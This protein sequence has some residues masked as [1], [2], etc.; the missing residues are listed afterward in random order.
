MENMN[1]YMKPVVKD[2]G[3]YLAFYPAHEGG[4]SLNIKDVVAYIN[5]QGY[6][7]YDLIA[8]DRAIKSPEPQEVYIG[9]SNGNPFHEKVSI[10]LSEDNMLVYCTFYPAA[11]DTGNPATLEDIQDALTFQKV[12]YGI[13]DTAVN[14]LLQNREYCTRYLIGKG[15]PPKKGKDAEIQYFFSINRSLKPKHNEDGSVNYH[16]LDIISRVEKGQ[17]LARLIPSVPGEPGYNVLG[18]ELKPRDVQEL[19]LTY[20]NNIILSED[21]TEIYSDV[22][23]HASLVDG[24]V[25]VS[26]VYE[27]PADVD[28][29]TG[30]IDYPGNVYVKGNV[31]SGF[32][33]RAD[34]DI[35]VDGVV[36]GAELYSKGQIIVKRGIHGTGKGILTAEGNVV[37]KFIESATVNSGGYIET[38]S[39]IHSNVSAKTD[40]NVE[41]GKGFIIGGTVRASHKVSARTLG[42]PMGAETHIEVGIEPEKLEHYNQLQADAKKIAKEIETI[43]PIILN[44]SEKLKAGITIPAD[45]I[46]FMKTQVTALK[47]L[48]EKILPINAEL[49]LLKTE[50]MSMGRA[51]VEARNVVHAGVTVKISDLSFTTKDERKFCQF[52][53]KDGEIKIMNL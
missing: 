19:K 18:E 3:F 26:G 2:G 11:D 37:I 41:G 50:F 12:T 14:T 28:N 31:K 20:A 48:Q 43:R 13:N 16:E 35:I 46:A 39:I 53:K 9:N 30:N 29:S 5:A 15:T 36:E 10:S 24:K 34:G 52:V 27:V 40:I 1:S 7:E 47:Q 4:K 25:F 23:G 32:V 33:I 49:N 22:T 6:S 44:Y 8:I 17:L 21:G 38:E 45:K 42:S 51:K